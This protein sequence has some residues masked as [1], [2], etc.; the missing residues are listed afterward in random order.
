MSLRLFGDT[1]TASCEPFPD[2]LR[3]IELVE[4]RLRALAKSR[5]IL[6]KM[7]YVFTAMLFPATRA[8]FQVEG[9]NV[10]FRDAILTALAAERHRLRTGTYPTMVSQLVPDFLSTVPADPFDGQPLRLFAIEDTLTIYSVGKDGKDNG[11]IQ[12]TSAG[13][14]DIVIQLRAK[15]GHA[16]E[17]P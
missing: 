13:D 17:S 10:A 12:S 9:R 11:G 2:A 15:K 16:T 7:Q 8:A 5:N 3:Q 6:E 4:D 1:I 14:P